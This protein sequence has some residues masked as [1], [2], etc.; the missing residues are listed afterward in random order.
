MAL[1]HLD[2]HMLGEFSLHSGSS[3][4]NDGNNRSRKIWLLMAY[5]IYYRN[6][7][8]T[9][10][11]LITLLWRDEEGSTNPGNA[12]KTMFHRLRT[13]LNDLDPHGGRELIRHQEGTYAWNTAVD[14]TLDIDEFDRYCREA[15]LAETPEK[16]LTSYL[17]A[18]P[19]YQGDFLS[20]MSAESWVV[21][22]SVYYHNL[23]VQSVLETIPLL[24]EAGRW[25]ESAQLCR[26]AIVHE[27]YMEDLY[28]H[29]MMAL[30]HMDDL[31]GVVKV[32]E[33]MSELLLSNFG[34]MPSEESLSLYRQATKT[35]NERTVSSGIILEQLRES[36]DPGGAL[37]CEYDLFKTLYHW[38]A[39]AVVRNG[40]AVHLALVSITDSA[41]NELPRRS[42]DRVV[43]NLQDLIRSSLRRGDVV[44]RCSVSQFILLL[45]QANYEHSCMVCDRILR[46][47][48]R[49]Y[50]HSP[51]VLHVSVHPLEPNQ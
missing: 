3:E 31:P 46:S 4:I 7:P 38:I 18:L 14:I 34:I 9:S 1:S 20:K 32:Y 45:P 15:S 22:I 6:R 43:E 2:I 36:T 39:R 24:E 21:P 35:V 29:L 17:K 51:A 13:S 33:D 19:L 49:Q 42:L 44:A 37:V 30:T 40:D 23:Y 48:S 16:K 25:E 50:P 28:R 47:F 12:L 27:P 26:Q 41:G 5:M 11:E 8:I 10:E